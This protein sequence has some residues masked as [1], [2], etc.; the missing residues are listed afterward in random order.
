MAQILDMIPSLTLSNIDWANRTAKKPQ[1]TTVYPFVVSTCVI[2]VLRPHLFLPDNKP[3]LINMERT[4]RA[5]GTAPPPASAPTSQAVPF[6][7]TTLVGTSTASSSARSGRQ[8][9]HCPFFRCSS[10][11]ITSCKLCP[12]WSTQWKSS[13]T[14]TPSK[15]CSNLYSLFPATW[16]T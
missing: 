5:R 2:L 9:I 3:I 1:R 4:L 7:L 14:A 10:M 8:M 16:R 12:T 15:L 6:W 11:R 13:S